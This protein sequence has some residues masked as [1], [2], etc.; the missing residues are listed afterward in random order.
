MDD[1]SSRI[2]K[3]NLKILEFE[4]TILYKAGKSN[5][6]A[7]GLSGMFLTKGVSTKRCRRKR[8]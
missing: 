8:E 7:A 3:L 5:S 6:K 1:S 4:Y 2:I